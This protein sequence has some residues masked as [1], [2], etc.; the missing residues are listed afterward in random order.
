MTRFLARLLC[1]LTA[2][3]DWVWDPAG[4]Y[5]GATCRACGRTYMPPAKRHD[6]VEPVG[7]ARA[8]SPRG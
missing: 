3:H 2:S 1:R 6:S 8:P 4:N 7:P 5:D